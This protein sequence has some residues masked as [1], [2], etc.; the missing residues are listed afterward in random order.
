MLAGECANQGFVDVTNI[1][2]DSPLMNLYPPCVLVLGPLLLFVLIMG[3][4]ARS[5][6][7]PALNANLH[8]TNN[9]LLRPIWLARVYV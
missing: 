6:Y 1:R 3:I 7:R 5:F 2:L 8:A 4:N 9:A